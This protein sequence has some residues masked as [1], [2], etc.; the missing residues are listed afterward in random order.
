VEREGIR[1][2]VIA[3]D[4]LRVEQVRVCRAESKTHA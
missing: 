3:G 1:I 4:E 2:E